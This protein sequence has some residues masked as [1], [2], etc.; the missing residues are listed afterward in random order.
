MD[1]D[2]VISF[3]LKG[4]LTVFMTSKGHTRK[5]VLTTSEEVLEFFSAIMDSVDGDEVD[6]DRKAKN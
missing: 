5:K 2:T 3:S 4:S 6:W 1:E